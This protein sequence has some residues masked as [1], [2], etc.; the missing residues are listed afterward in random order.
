MICYGTFLGIWY[1]YQPYD[2][3]SAQDGGSNLRIRCNDS[4]QFDMGYLKMGGIQLINVWELGF[5]LHWT[6]KLNAFRGIANIV[7]PF[8]PMFLSNA[9]NASTGY[10]T[11][12]VPSIWCGAWVVKTSSDG[13]V[14]Q[15]HGCFS[16]CW[17]VVWNTTFMTFHLLG[18]I[19]PTDELHHFSEG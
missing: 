6:L 3:G 19:I 13:W 16:M 11:Q 15:S 14:P 12:G 2:M 17:L 4:Q 9:I 7:A 8:V 5:R 18:I 1:H 10:Q